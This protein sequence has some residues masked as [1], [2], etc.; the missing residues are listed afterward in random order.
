MYGLSDVGGTDA[1]CQKDWAINLLADFSADFP[2]MHSPS[3]AKLFDL[4]GWV[5]RIKKKCIDKLCQGLGFFERLIAHNVND[6]NE[7]HRWKL[8][9]QPLKL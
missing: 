4:Q 9:A 1:T 8:T 6:L 2:I 3:A 7:L 5:A